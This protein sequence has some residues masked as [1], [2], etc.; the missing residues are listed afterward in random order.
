MPTPKGFDV[1]LLSVAD[2]TMA[3]G[4]SNIKASNGLR[5]IAVTATAD[6]N[7]AN[8]SEIV[9]DLGDHYLD[10]LCAQYGNLTWS[11]EGV[12]DS[13][14][15]TMAGIQRGFAIAALG[16]FVILAT[17]FRSYLQPVVIM[18]I[19]PFGI[20]GA[21]LGHFFMGIPL[22][23]LSLFGIIALSGVVVND[24]IVFMECFNELIARGVPVVDALVQSGVRRFRAIFLT[25]ATTFMGLAPLVMERNL[26]AQI[27]IPMAVSIA[28]G[29]VF[30]MFVTLLLTPCLVAITNDARRGVYRLLHK[31]W[32]APEDVEPG[33]NRNAGEGDTPM[34]HPTPEIA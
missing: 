8:P 21:V 31:Q 34:T 26:Q 10:N 1:P 19:I 20:V 2:I 33:R 24:S 28:A 32:P 29:T 3:P 12:E 6:I 7:K 14:R 25:S 23:F 5:R 17:T 13:N 16:I 9:A 11:V 30:A 22:T 15:E 27:V 18:F 4:V